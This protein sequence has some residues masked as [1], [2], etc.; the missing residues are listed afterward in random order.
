MKFTKIAKSISN[1]VPRRA[2]FFVPGHDKKF[3]A[4]APNFKVDC[5]VLEL[6]DGVAMSSKKQA[7]ENVAE[8]LNDL[9]TKTH[10]CFEL[11]V[12]VNSPSSGMLKDDL[13]VLSKA[14]HTPQAFMIPKI[15]SVEELAYIADAFRTTYGEERINNKNIKLVIWIESARALLDMPRILNNTLNLHLNTGFPRLDA[16]VF[17][18][19]DFCA[20]IGATRSSIGTETLYARQRF[21]TCCKAFNLQAIDSVFIDYKNLDDLKQQSI[22]GFSWG[23]TGKQII[24]PRQ[25]ETTQNAFYPSADKIKWAEELIDLF[26]KHQKD[27]KGA[28][29][30]RG[31]M[32]DKPLLLQAINI[33]EMKRKIEEIN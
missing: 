33:V 29:I 32:I 25:I 16:V 28:F 11:G 7:R 20:N 24:H 1:F 26:E 2:L 19:D 4:K 27:G 15:D 18:S 17:G 5:L 30:F 13:S 6:E 9:P 22:E 10:K 31:Q 3:L 14:K 8:Y 12:R 21:V 23:F